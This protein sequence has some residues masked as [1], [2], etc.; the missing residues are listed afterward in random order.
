MRNYFKILIWKIRFEGGS[1]K[2]FMLSR[3]SDDTKKKL[4][5][6]GNFKNFEESDFENPDYKSINNKNYFHL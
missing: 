2:S 1:Q 6:V 4:K 5:F 3:N